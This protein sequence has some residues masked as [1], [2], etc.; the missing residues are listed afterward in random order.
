MFCSKCGNT[1]P[2]TARFCDKCGTPLEQ[3]SIKGEPTVVQTVVKPKT[4]IN[5]KEKLLI[6]AA[7]ALV[8]LFMVIPILF[9][10]G[11]KDVMKLQKEAALVEWSGYTEELEQGKRVRT[12][13]LK[14]VNGENVLLQFVY[15][16]TGELTSAMVG[17]PERYERLSINLGELCKDKLP[18]DIEEL[19]LNASVNETTSHEEIPM[20][21]GL[22]LYSYKEEAKTVTWRVDGN[23]YSTEYAYDNKN[24]VTR[25]VL[26]SDEGATEEYRYSYD[27]QGRVTGVKFYGTETFETRINYDSNG[28]MVSMSKYDSDGNKKF[29]YTQTFDAQNRITQKKFVGEASLLGMKYNAEKVYVFRYDEQGNLIELKHNT[30]SEKYGYD[31]N[32]NQTEIRHYNEEGVHEYTYAKEFDKLGNLVKDQEYA[33]YGT[34]PYLKKETEYKYDKNSN[35]IATRDSSYSYEAN[36]DYS[37]VNQIEANEGEWRN[38]EEDEIPQYEWEITYYTDEEWEQYQHDQEFTAL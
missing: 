29:D 33:I 5:V 30:Y 31:E 3:K 35:V 37:V 23:S 15:E 19:D 26:T 28:N 4:E 27:S 38:V 7:I 20:A 1:L 11:D 34:N 36:S 32:G 21:T 9:K 13:T 8:A 12:A 17:A 25:K 2:D 14:E 18:I 24:R 6:A 16:I 22:N 10:T